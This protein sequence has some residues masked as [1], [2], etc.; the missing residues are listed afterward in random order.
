MEEH[1]RTANR[2]HP[3]QHAAPQCSPIRRGSIR[4]QESCVRAGHLVWPRRMP[5]TAFSIP[6]MTRPEPTLNSIGSSPRVSSHIVP[7]SS[8]PVKCSFTTSP[9]STL[10]A[11]ARVPRAPDLAAPTRPRVRRGNT[12]APL[13]MG[14]AVAARLRERT[15]PPAGQCHA[16][17]LGKARRATWE[18]A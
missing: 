7:S 9:S 15:A 12:D 18:G 2:P 4:E 14:G 17:P 16:L 5:T 13:S 11:A 1:P 3:V 8:V 10:S 6:G